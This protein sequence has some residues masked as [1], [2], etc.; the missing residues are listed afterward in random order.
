MART[1]RRRRRSRGGGGKRA[2]TGDDRTSSSSSSR[3]LRPR[4][5][6]RSPAQVDA[7]AAAVATPSPV[8][9]TTLTH[10]LVDTPAADTAS[11]LSEAEQ[12]RQ[13]AK[14]IRQRRADAEAAAL[15]LVALHHGSK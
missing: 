11:P 4:M 9:P 1:L 15:A 13:R 3:F 2:G 10:H 12:L 7:A 6:P 8:R 14:E 5:L